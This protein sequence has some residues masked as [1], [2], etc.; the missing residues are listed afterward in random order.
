MDDPERW[1][2]S[3]PVGVN[4]RYCSAVV[5]FDAQLGFE[6]IRP[7]ALAQAEYGEFAA[8]HPGQFAVAEIA[9]AGPSKITVVSLYGLWETMV[10]S[11]D[12][13]A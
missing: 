13:Y 1:S 12:I 11:G 5:C 2:V 7:T 8:S 3:V 6:P 9:R 10:D 4:R